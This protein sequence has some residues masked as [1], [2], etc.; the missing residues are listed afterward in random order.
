[1]TSDDEL[2]PLKPI[3]ESAT[4]KK[5]KDNDE[6][7]DDKQTTISSTEMMEMY[8]KQTSWNYKMSKTKKLMTNK[9]SKKNDFY[10]MDVAGVF[11]ENSGNYVG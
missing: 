2:P 10:K 7:D 9:F 11:I 3:E 8:E 1:M 5:G 6:D 4:A